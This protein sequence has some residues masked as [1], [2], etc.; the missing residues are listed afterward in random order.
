MEINQAESPLPTQLTEIDK[1]L[2]AGSF[3]LS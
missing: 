2:R 1:I 3:I